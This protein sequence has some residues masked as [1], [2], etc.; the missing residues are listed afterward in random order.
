MTV[1]M[2]I[3]ALWVVMSGTFYTELPMYERNLLFL[4]SEIEA[5]RS[6]EV[7]VHLYQTI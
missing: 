2:K 4:S 5:H 3:T 7:F 6:S 1:N